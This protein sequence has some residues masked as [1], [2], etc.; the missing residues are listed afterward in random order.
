V[1]IFSALTPNP[2]NTLEPPPNPR[3]AI[4]PRGMF[5]CLSHQLCVAT[6]RSRSRWRRGPDSNRRIKVLQTNPLPLGYR[7]LV[8]MEDLAEC[9]NEAVAPGLC[10]RISYLMDVGASLATG[11]F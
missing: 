3:A 9:C 5:N 6:H 8:E 2:G 4:S 7:A 11:S 1:L 10:H